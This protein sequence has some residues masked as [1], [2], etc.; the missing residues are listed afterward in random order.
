MSLDIREKTLWVT[1]ASSGIGRAL[2]LRLAKQNNFVI[3]SSRRFDA[4]VE[5]QK[6]APNHI[7]ILDC[8]LSDDQEVQA[9]PQRLADLT[10]HL[11]MV[12]ACAG[13]CE[14]DNDLQLDLAMYRRVFDA[15][16]FALINTLRCALPLLA[17]SRKPVFAALGSLSSVVPFPR[18]EAYGSSKAALAY[19]LESVRAD[20]SLT[21]LRVV[22]IRPGFVAT[23][24]TQGND[25]GMPFLM[26]PEQ[27]AEHIERGLCGAGHT[28]DFPR[29]LSWP[30]RFLGF[31]STLWFRFFAP[32][33]TRI[34]AL[35]KS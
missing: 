19:F 2:V 14:Y 32:K 16:F 3:A 5:L 15:N 21:P 33:M 4:L 11:D 27:A 9:L 23:R 8:D 1:G 17:A 34:R 28:I 26:S 31:F 13:T 7:Q 29:R 25:F 10:D 12:V 6:T 30:L 22:H 18:A 20:T 35:R 24:L